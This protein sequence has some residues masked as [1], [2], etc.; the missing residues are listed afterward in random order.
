MSTEDFKQMVA[1][2]D[3]PFPMNSDTQPNPAATP[4]TDVDY[5]KPTPETDAFMERIDD[6][7]VDPSVIRAALHDMECE[8]DSAQA[9]LAAKDAEIARL[10]ADGAASAFVD[11]AIRAEKAEA[12]L[13]C[14]DDVLTRNGIPV[15]STPGD[16]L[17]I[18]LIK[19]FSERDQLRAEVERLTK[20]RDDWAACAKRTDAKMLHEQADH[21]KTVDRLIECR[22][23]LAAAQE[24]TEQVNKWF[25]EIR[26]CAKSIV[27]NMR[28]DIAPELRDDVWVITAA[29]HAAVIMQNC[30]AIDAARSKESDTAG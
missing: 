19:L 30:A 1:P 2:C 4:R 25:K 20:E 24:D 29:C 5:N 18:N 26:E 6:S 3:D 8:R 12:K 22:A 7:E 17:V 16:E 28:E 15:G 14:A 21:N 27:R 11:M 23:E 10:K 9:A 13:R